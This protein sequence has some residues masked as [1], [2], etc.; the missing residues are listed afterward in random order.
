MN[1]IFRIG[2]YFGL[3]GIFG[4]TTSYVI[5]SS[6]SIIQNRCYTYAVYND[7]G[8]LLSHPLE[9]FL[10]HK[11]LA[12]NAKDRFTD[13]FIIA[14]GWNYDLQESITNYKQYADQLHIELKKYFQKTQDKMVDFNCQQSAMA[15]H[16]HL[17][18]GISKRIKPYLIFVTWPS[19]SRPVTGLFSSILPFGLDDALKPISLTLDRIAFFLPTTWKQSMNAAKIALGV[20]LP[21]EYLFESQATRFYGTGSLRDRIGQD[22]PL[23]SL[24]YDLLSIIR[25]HQIGSSIPH[26][27]ERQLN[28]HLIGHSYGAKIAMLSAV[29]GIRQ[30]YIKQEFQVD[31]DTFNSKYANCSKKA[32]TRGTIKYAK[33]S[34]TI[35]QEE[36][37]SEQQKIR[38]Q[39]AQ[40]NYPLFT[41][42][43][44]TEDSEKTL[45]L[46]KSLILFN[47]AF[48]MQE[49][50]YLYDTM[51]FQAEGEPTFLF[52]CR[53]RIRN[54]IQEI[55]KHCDTEDLLQ[56]IERKA[57]VYSRS[58]TLNLVPFSLSQLI[59]NNAWAQN[60]RLFPK[61]KR[62]IIPATLLERRFL[63][64]PLERNEGFETLM[65]FPIQI[66]K[67][68]YVL[69]SG[70]ISAP[71]LWIT[72]LLSS[73]TSALGFSGLNTSWP[74]HRWQLGELLAQPST[75][76]QYSMEL[77]MASKQKKN[78]FCLL[79]REKLPPD[80]SIPFKISRNVFYSF[81][82]SDVFNS[83]PHSH[84]DLR[85]TLPSICHTHQLR[86]R[87]IQNT[88]AKLIIQEQDE[89]FPT[90]MITALIGSSKDQKDHQAALYPQPTETND[91]TL[92]DQSN[93]NQ[94][95]ATSPQ[96]ALEH[97]PPLSADRPQQHSDNPESENTSL[98]NCATTNSHGPY[99]ELF[100]HFPMKR[101]SVIV[102]KQQLQCIKD[103]LKWNEDDQIV[104]SNSGYQAISINKTQLFHE[105][106][107][108]S[109]QN[110]DSIANLLDIN[111]S[112]TLHQDTWAQLV[113][114]ILDDSAKDIS[115]WNIQHPLWT[116]NK[117]TQDFFEDAEF[118]GILHDTAY[119]HASDDPYD[120]STDWIAHDVLPLAHEKFISFVED[121]F[122]ENRKVS[123]F[124]LG[125]VQPSLINQL[126]EIRQSSN[127]TLINETRVLLSQEIQ[128]IIEEDNLHKY[129]E[130]SEVMM[131]K[132]TLKLWT[133][134]RH[135]ERDW[136]PDGHD[137]GG[138]DRMLLN[139][140]LLAGE[141]Y[142]LKTEPLTYYQYWQQRGLAKYG[143]DMLTHISN[144]LARNIS[145]V[146]VVPKP[147]KQKKRDHTLNF[148]LNFSLFQCAEGENCQSPLSNAFKAIPS[149][150]L[151]CYT[152][153]S[154][155]TP[156]KVAKVSTIHP[157]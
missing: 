125:R 145:R 74:G 91:F 13:V 27:T 17:D 119:L 6:N 122:E 130:F 82:G 15:E 58:D 111:T 48:H 120:I 126:Q 102:G 113:K 51:D 73:S 131:D 34:L 132:T 95:A 148:V 10:Y 2:L 139:R 90:K 121:L 80:S 143:T 84:N 28:L 110:L 69:T 53:Q 128:Q 100:L 75:T 117:H 71:G 36:K 94:I 151:A 60:A 85:S 96:F 83:F 43:L 155:T 88:L 154:P 137:L 23:S 41:S 144:V 97:I 62:N 104:Y 37:K 46:V 79:S 56:H 116:N 40:N 105:A 47:P 76:N 64:L 14:H 134:V 72:R 78:A 106:T 146:C 3:L 135:F 52:P 81:N 20:R 133:E 1:N 59:I 22:V 127:P 68:G 61:Q 35:C 32:A 7:Q 67:G 65:K 29:E 45:P 5:P 66:L 55:D 124:L 38:L 118:G 70:I 93:T 87:I 39:I 86:D 63:D 140:R 157:N 129:Q 4:C 149:S 136:R 147:E 21:N 12:E 114:K 31:F 142:D 112:Y 57:I 150:D 99:Y 9:D 153:P 103:I 109:L 108:G 44:Q 16:H 24:V 123:G 11:N 26:K 30:W 19:A 54:G 138:K 18:T 152:E 115:V 92:P 101:V 89:A 49:L 42:I 50:N 156:A 33:E 77:G 107:V 141:F 98:S 8:R 25:P